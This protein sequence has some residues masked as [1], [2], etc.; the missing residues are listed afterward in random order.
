MKDDWLETYFDWCYAVAV[1]GHV[2]VVASIGYNFV[3]VLD[4]NLLI[5]ESF[6]MNE[7]MMP[8]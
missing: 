4:L 7:W 8:N 5:C 3:I 6:Y 2:A 1:I